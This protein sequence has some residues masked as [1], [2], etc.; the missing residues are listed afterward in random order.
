MNPRNFRSPVFETGTLNQTRTLFQKV[1]GERFEL[2]R[3]KTQI[4]KTCVA[5]ITPSRHFIFIESIVGFE[6]T[7]NEFA[8]R[9]PTNREYAHNLINS[10]LL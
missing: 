2:S 9:S 6:P 4:P 10:A 8:I 7:K 1:P 3:P 5:A